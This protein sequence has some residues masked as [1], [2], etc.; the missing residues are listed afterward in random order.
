MHTRTHTHTHSLSLSLSLTLT[1]TFTLT[2]ALTLQAGDGLAAL[3]VISRVDVLRRGASSE[4]GSKKDMLHKQASRERGAE[5]HPN[6]PQTPRS[7][8][9]PDCILMDR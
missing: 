9:L 8:D 1:H 3:A 4:N 2:L 6:A 7:L 5:A